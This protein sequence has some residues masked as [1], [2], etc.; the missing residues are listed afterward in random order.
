MCNLSMP[1]DDTKATA[2]KSGSFVSALTS[3]IIYVKK[4][5]TR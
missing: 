3:T 2:L 5:L 1:N 4:Q